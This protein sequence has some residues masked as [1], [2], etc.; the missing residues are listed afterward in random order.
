MSISIVT[1]LLTGISLFL[2]GMSLM[3]DGLKKVAGNKL[4]MILY[5]LTGSPLKGGL[6]G[7]GIT[8]VI[9]SSSATS[10]MVV[11]FVNSGIMKLRQAI[12]IVL[13]AIFGTSI[14]G[15]VI[16]LSQLEGTGWLSLF[17]TSS[18]TCISALIGIY[19]KMFAKGRTKN[20]VGEIF[21]GFAVLMFGM[22]AMS[23]SVSH[24]RESEAFISMLTRFSNPFIGIIVG[25]AFTCILQSA[26][27]AVGI[28]QALSITGAITFEVALPLTMGIAVGAAVPVLLSAIGATTDGKRTAFAYLLTNAIGAVLFGIAFYSINAFMK[29]AFMDTVL[30]MVTVS[31]VNTVYRFIIVLIQLPLTGHIATITEKLIKDTVK[32]EEK[33]IQ[34]L[35]LEERFVDHPSLAIEQSRNAIYDMADKAKE[36]IMNAIGLLHTYDEGK[37]EKVVSLEDVVDV[38]EDKIGT[39]LLKLTAKELDDEQNSSVSKFLRMITDFERMSDHAM[40]LAEAAKEL[41]EKGTKFSDFALDELMI[42]ENATKEVVELTMNVFVAGDLTLATRVEPLEEH[43][44]NLCN[45]IKMRHVERLQAGQC[46]FGSGFVFNDILTNYERIADHCSNIA[47]AMIAIDS[48]SFDIHEYINSMEYKKDESFE[49]YFKE[50]SMKY[51]LSKDYLGKAKAEGEVLA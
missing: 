45:E 42:L 49:L 8:A 20:N 39:Y 31:I 3:G 41:S 38:Y 30:D 24:L 51:A 19:L 40:N 5:R 21:M 10:V 15:W 25:M 27:A 18:L 13:G 28:L 2:Y 44:D 36:N 50:Y 37:Y 35:P 33:G 46:T 12:P 14:T 11:G 22:S 16:C 47:V 9:Q 17:S 43:I 48:K 26:S 7:A 34:T 29:F 6:F 23:G 4:E 32:T 1:Q